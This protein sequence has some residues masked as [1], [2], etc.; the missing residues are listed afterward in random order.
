MKREL[1]DFLIR[2]LDEANVKKPCFV[3]PDWG[4]FNFFSS[5]F[6]RR[7]IEVNKDEY[8]LVM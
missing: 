8:N 3:K 7:L 4:N 1:L 2:I 5:D 6:N